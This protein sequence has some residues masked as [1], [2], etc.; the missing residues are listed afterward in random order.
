[1]LGAEL[2]LS[3]GLTEGET[4]REELGL[5]DKSAEGGELGLP[6]G[7]ALGEA[8]GLSDG[9][10]LGEARGVALGLFWTWIKSAARTD[11][12]NVSSVGK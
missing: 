12:R 3:D 2:G 7:L 6:D 9:L 4:L 1:V 11:G 10:A 8:L 5:R